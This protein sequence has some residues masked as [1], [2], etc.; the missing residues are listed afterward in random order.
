MTAIPEECIPAP[1]KS[2]SWL[3]KLGDK[4][5]D[6]TSKQWY[7]DWLA[8][9]TS[10]C[11]DLS[12]IAADNPGGEGQILWRSDRELLLSIN[13]N[14]GFPFEDEKK[15]QETIEHVFTFGLQPARSTGDM[16]FPKMNDF[17]DGV[18]IYTTYQPIHAF[19]YLYESKTP[20]NV[21]VYL[22]DAP[23]GILRESKAEH[24]GVFF[25]GGIKGEFIKGAYINISNMHSKTIYI[26]N[27][28][29]FAGKI[30]EG[31]FDLIATPWSGTNASVYPDS[32][33]TFSP[34]GEPVGNIAY[35]YKTG[36]EVH[37]TLENSAD[38]SWYS[39]YINGYDKGGEGGITTLTKDDQLLPAI[40]VYPGEVK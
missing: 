22:I 23:G 28:S 38:K 12:R 18:Y 4:A 16:G 35:R 7:K 1:G 39:W 14:P 15:C 5:K 25:P 8:T 10:L 30:K 24:H 34:T 31:Y 26:D 11:T 21:I 20:D 36:T 3:Q 2:P 29:Y 33:I 37:I 9:T 40:V 13:G 17:N 32:K 27:P 6:Y 19:N